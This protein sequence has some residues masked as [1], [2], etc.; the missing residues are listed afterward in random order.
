MTKNQIEAA[1]AEIADFCKYAEYASFRDGLKRILTKYFAEPVELPDGEGKQEKRTA[2]A[3]ECLR[4][5]WQ[6]FDA[7]GI[8]MGRSQQAFL[9][10][11]AQSLVPYDHRYSEM[12]DERY[13]E[14]DRLLRDELWDAGKEAVDRQTLALGLDVEAAAHPQPPA[15]TGEELERAMLEWFD[16]NKGRGKVTSYAEI[17]AQTR[18]IVEGGG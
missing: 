17:A 11:S 14:F 4:Q 7:S 13:S 18:R 5:V 1:A 16:R 12:T 3:M 10:E 8:S 9:L 6:C 2:L 15:V